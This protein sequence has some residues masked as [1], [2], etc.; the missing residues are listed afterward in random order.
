[1]VSRD[2][3]AKMDAIRILLAEAYEH[4][5]EHSDGNCKFSEGA[6]S[7]NFP[8]FFWREDESSEAPSVSIYSYVLGPRRGR[9][10]KNVDE[11]LKAVREWHASEMSRDYAADEEEWGGGSDRD[12]G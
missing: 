9:Y 2:F 3:E 10:F 6:I 5:F 1:M 11:A 12:D 4:Y 7:I 8:P